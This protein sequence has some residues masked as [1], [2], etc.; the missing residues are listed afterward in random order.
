MTNYQDYYDVLKVKRTAT[1]NQI[2]QAYKQLAKKH[3][4]DL[5]N[6]KNDRKFK[7][8]S[9]SYNTLKDPQRKLKYDIVST[10]PVRLQ[11]LKDLKNLD[12]FSKFKKSYQNLSEYTEFLANYIYKKSAD[13]LKPK[14]QEL[15]LKALDKFKELIK[16]Y[17]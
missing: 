10:I 15:K 12:N 9:E 1:Q 11:D 16:S 8:I 5:P 7:L 6:I 13:T 14:A 3:H 2:K 4:P 17:Q